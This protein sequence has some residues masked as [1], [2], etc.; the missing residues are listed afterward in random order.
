MY[1]SGF[2]VVVEAESVA[3]DAGGA[4]LRQVQHGRHRHARVRRVPAILKDGGAVTIVLL[5]LYVEIC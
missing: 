4:G 2:G 5:T 1:L 3:A